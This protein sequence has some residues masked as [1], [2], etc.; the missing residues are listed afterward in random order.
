M[1]MRPPARA[2]L[3][4][5]AF[6]LALAWVLPSC[7]G[8]TREE[9]ERQAAKEIKE[10]MKDVEAIAL[11]Q[12][13]EPDVV[14]E[15]QR[16]LAALKEYQGEITGKLDSVTVNAI[17]AFQRT[18]GLEDDGILDEETRKKLAQAAPPA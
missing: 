10:S 5:S 13:V 11:E 16:Q 6:I 17:Q 15:V 1:K 2:V 14:K 3:L 4:R 12:K 7:S 9:R 18:A 8:G